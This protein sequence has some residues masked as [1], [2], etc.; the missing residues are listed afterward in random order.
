MVIFT[1]ARCAMRNTQ[2]SGQYAVRGVQHCRLQYMAQV[3]TPRQVAKSATSIFFQH[4]SNLMIQ[5]VELLC[6]LL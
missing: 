1:V 3:H 2:R 5:N 6:D 4:N